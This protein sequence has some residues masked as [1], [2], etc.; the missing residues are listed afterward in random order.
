MSD[1]KRR[2]A[3]NDIARYRNANRALAPTTQADFLGYYKP[4]QD[5]LGPESIA[6]KWHEGDSNAA[7]DAV[8][9]ETLIRMMAALDP[10]WYWHPIHSQHK[11]NHQA[12]ATGS[13][14]IHNKWYDNQEDVELN[15]RHMALLTKDIFRISEMICHTILRGPMGGVPGNFRGTNFYQEWLA[16]DGEKTTKF[17]KPGEKGACL[18]NPALIMMLGA[19]RANVYLGK[20]TN[21][22]IGLIGLLDDPETLWNATYPEYLASLTSA[23]NDY[24]Q[25]PSL[26]IKS[27]APYD[28]QLIKLYYGM[29]IPEL[30]CVVYDVTTGKRYARESDATTATHHLAHSPDGYADLR[31]FSSPKEKGRFPASTWFKESP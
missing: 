28:H 17:F 23:F 30:P 31:T 11:P 29:R 22:N 15:L 10:L 1:E 25:T 2:V 7:P 14:A 8:P 9:S 26:F 5:V 3:I 13:M 12:A 21:G 20:S 19:F 24:D 6:V 18:P 27:S 4:F 16:K